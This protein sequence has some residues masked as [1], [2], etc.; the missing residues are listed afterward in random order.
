MVIPLVNLE[1]LDPIFC[2]ENV[3]RELNSDRI[4]HL[5]ET[6]QWLIDEFKPYDESTGWEL[7]KYTVAFRVDKCYVNEKGE[8]IADIKVIDNSVWGY[9]LSFDF[10]ENVI[11]A[12]KGTK[13]Y[14]N[15][16]VDGKTVK[17]EL[18]HITGFSYMKKYKYDEGL[19]K[20]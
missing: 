19:Y 11:F 14:E 5:I 12:L 6:K 15:I 3:E 13:K 10:P 4:K 7:D 16:V 8:V 1:K 2:K 17:K 9:L 18:L 20:I